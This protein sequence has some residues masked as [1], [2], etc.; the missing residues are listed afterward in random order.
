MNYFAL[1]EEK[2]AAIL[3]CTRNLSNLSLILWM[4]VL[5]LLH[6]YFPL[7]GGCQSDCESGLCFQRCLLRGLRGSFLLTFHPHFLLDSD[8]LPELCSCLERTVN[9]RIWSPSSELCP[10]S[11]LGHRCCICV[12]FLRDFVFEICSYPPIARLRG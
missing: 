7:K 9:L 8:L 10:C 3:S 1:N 6:V 4:P 12:D 2:L 11:G 5:L